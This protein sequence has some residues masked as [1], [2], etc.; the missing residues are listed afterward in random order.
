MKAFTR[1]SLVIA[2]VLAMLIPTYAQPVFAAKITTTPSGYT[3]AEDVVYKK[4]GK[5]VHNWGARG[6]TS[7]F[8][9]TYALDF[10]SASESYATLSQIAGGSSQSNAPSS[11]LYKSLQTVMKSH[12]SFINNYDQ[13]KDYCK[14]TD[15]VLGDSAYLSSFYSGKMVGGNWVSGGT[16]WNREHTWPN[17]KGLAGSDENDIMMIRPT[18]PTE[19][20]SRGNKAYGV[21]S[22]YHNP[23]ESVH[24]DCARIA[25][26]VYVRW[27]NT[28]YMWGSAGVIENLEILL[29]WMEE[30]PVDTWEMGRN[31]AVQSITGTRNIFVDYPEY[32]WLLFGKGNEMP[33][34]MATPSGIACG[35]DY[36]VPPVGGGDGGD[37]PVKPENPP[38]TNAKETIELTSTALGLGNYADSSAQVG[39]YT[40]DFIELGDYGSGIQMRNKTKTSTLWNATEFNYPITRIDFLYNETQAKHTNEKALKIELGTTSAFN[41]QTTYLSTKTGVVNYSIVPEGEYTY[42]RF[43]DNITYSLYFDSITIY[44]GGTTEGG[45]NGGSDTPVKPDEPTEYETL[46]IAEALVIGEGLAHDA[47]T[48]TKYYISGTITEIK[49]TY[50]GNMTIKDENGDSIYVYGT[51][52]ADGTNRFGY[53]E[54]PPQVGD[55]VKLLS[56]VSNY[57]GAQLKNAWI[58]EYG[59]NGGSNTDSSINSSVNSSTPI[60]P[61]SSV[62]NN[63]SHEYGAWEIVASATVDTDG[64]KVRTCEKCGHKEE[65]II[66]ATDLGSCKASLSVSSL[67]GMMLVIA[68]AVVGKKKIFAN[69]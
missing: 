44:L 33:T 49:D 31:D 22:E 42:V 23:G 43:S 67:G 2:L 11:A 16:T 55:K 14:Y 68:L 48:D 60:K 17:S 13:I 7:T 45:G 52:D 66:P 37:T 64:L 41:S 51:F 28:S 29:Q 25:L 62:N 39:G 38:V 21:S 46:S 54:N 69:N 63:C 19:N 24:G 40:F 8:L 4:T 18:I 26:Y 35:G 59:S 15:C 20:G 32:A 10:Y 30:D 57:N 58:I 12:H 61:D 50:Y 1:I 9:S 27:G 6:E 53:Y 36:P 56:V 47:V 5:Y 3:C 34:D 65:K